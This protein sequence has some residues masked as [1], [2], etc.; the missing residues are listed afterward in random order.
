MNATGLTCAIRKMALAR[1]LLARTHA[2]AKM[3]LLETE[4]CAIVSLSEIQEFM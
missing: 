4:R 3:V 2:H 1:M